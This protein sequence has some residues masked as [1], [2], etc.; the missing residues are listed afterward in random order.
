MVAFGACGGMPSATGW[1]L[2][3]LN[4]PDDSDD[5]NHDNNDDLPSHG[6]QPETN[7]SDVIF[8]PHPPNL[9]DLPYSKHQDHPR[10]HVKSSGQRGT[11][12]CIGL[13]LD[14]LQYPMVSE[15]LLEKIGLHRFVRYNPTLPFPSHSIFDLSTVGRIEIGWSY[16]DFATQS[17]RSGKNEFYVFTER[18]DK[19]YGM[20]F[21]LP[22]SFVVG[23]PAQLGRRRLTKGDANK[24]GKPDTAISETPAFSPDIVKLRLPGHLSDLLPL[25]PAIS[26]WLEP[27]GQGRHWLHPLA[28]RGLFELLRQPEAPL[29][30]DQPSLLSRQATTV[31]GSESST[32]AGETALVKTDGGNA[33]RAT[34]LAPTG[35]PAVDS[36]PGALDGPAN[37][38]DKLSPRLI[39]TD[40]PEDNTNDATSNISPAGT[41]KTL[42]AV[43]GTSADAMPIFP[44]A[45]RL[46]GYATVNVELLAMLAP[47]T[48]SVSDTGGS[49]GNSSTRNTTTDLQ[50]DGADAS[51]AGNVE[52]GDGRSSF[53]K[54]AL[55]S[56][57]PTEQGPSPASHGSSIS[58]RARESSKDEDEDGGRRRKKPRLTEALGAPDPSLPVLKLACPYQAYEPHRPCFQQGKGCEN[59]SRL[60]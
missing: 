56:R 60:K 15:R 49:G 52:T 26:R 4:R 25:N 55:N 5:D 57:Q 10:T 18:G 41:N 51:M 6:L 2:K 23:S 58:S 13:R 34:K 29:V 14:S 40:D 36:F 32:E 43:E 44:R 59:I 1:Y 21:F 17:Q 37:G 28:L 47:R 42:S 7:P 9:P 27:F 48:E 30:K 35:P 33:Y 22:N 8:L 11:L 20:E 54:A 12:G 19:S 38:D 39:G 46:V 3:H 16:V 50:D 53:S 31:L 24:H 45:V